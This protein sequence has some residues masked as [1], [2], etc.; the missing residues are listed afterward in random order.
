M[1]RTVRFQ[2]KGNHTLIGVLITGIVLVIFAGFL[3][4][5]PQGNTLSHRV[6]PNWDT[7]MD[8]LV[9]NKIGTRLDKDTTISS[10]S[11]ANFKTM[12]HDVPLSE[13]SKAADDANV[14]ATLYAK[15]YNQQKP[16]ARSL[17][18]ALY[19]RPELNTL[20][21]DIA[22]SHWV[23]AANDYNDILKNGKSIASISESAKKSANNS[24]K[25]M[26]DEGSKLYNDSFQNG[27]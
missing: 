5:S 24:A 12:I 19:T 21:E 17:I 1:Q 23:K 8:M 22:G 20:R 15:Y 26:Q 27:Q 4:L 2:N 14:A 13:I 16:N 11:R 3:F 7:P 10:T 6:F 18:D 25:K 9:K